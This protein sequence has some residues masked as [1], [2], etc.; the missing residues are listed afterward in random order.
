MADGDSPEA[1]SPNSDDSASRKSPVDSPRRYRIG[2]HLRHLGR[3]SQV[4]WQNLAAEP[5]ALAAVVNALVVD[6]R[7][8]H[9]KRADPSGS[10]AAA[11]SWAYDK[12]CDQER[13]VRKE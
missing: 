11:W 8:L 1:S 13:L 6:P 5:H 4:G 12:E 2:Q 10:P 3:P 7:C 9:G